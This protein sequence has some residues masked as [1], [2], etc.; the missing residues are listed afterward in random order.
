MPPRACVRIA[1]LGS[2]LALAAGARSAD[3]IDRD[4]GGR[5]IYE[6]LLAN[7]FEA[8]EQRARL[9]SGD[10]AGNEQ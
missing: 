1:L 10:R 6:R 3:A 4:P 2:A 9:V 5:E 7:R 8:F